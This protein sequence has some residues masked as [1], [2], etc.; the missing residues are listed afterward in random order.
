MVRREDLWLYLVIKDWCIW[1][2]KLR[3]AGG[4]RFLSVP[5]LA[6]GSLVQFG[7]NVGGMH[8]RFS[9]H[10]FFFFSAIASKKAYEM[11]RG[12]DCSQ[13]AEQRCLGAGLV[14]GLSS[15]VGFTVPLLFL[16]QG[17][18]RVNVQGRSSVGRQLVLYLTI[19]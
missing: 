9:T 19:M 12:W 16:D 17:R 1:T 18:V 6:A 5:T 11:G 4:G 10:F 14:I 8:N 7:Q 15:L 3:E 2:E 13:Q